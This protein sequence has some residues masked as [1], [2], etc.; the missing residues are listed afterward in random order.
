[1]C[2]RD[3]S[4]RRPPYGGWRV[5]RVNCEMLG[6]AAAECVSERISE[7]LS[8]ESCS[9]MRSDTRAV[10]AAPRISQDTRSMR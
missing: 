5:E 3:S 9:E 1:M 7:Q 8:R 6:A 4:I 10:V 2:I